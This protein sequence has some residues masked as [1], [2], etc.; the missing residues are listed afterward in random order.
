MK[1]FRFG[2]MATLIG[3]TPQDYEECCFKFEANEGTDWTVSSVE[4][5]LLS[6]ANEVFLDTIYTNARVFIRADLTGNAKSLDVYLSGM[7]TEPTQLSLQIRYIA[8][9]R[10]RG[11]TTLF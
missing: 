7:V 4:P 8:T 2:F 5:K 9:S 6:R 3:L 1:D 10:I 11:M